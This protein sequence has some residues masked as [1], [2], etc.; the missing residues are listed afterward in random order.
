MSNTKFTEGPW[1]FD[2]R[3]EHLENPAGTDIV[4][5]HAGLMG[6]AKTEE[7]VANSNL[8]EASPLLYKALEDVRNLVSEASAT[9]FNPHDGDWAD[10]LFESQAQ[11][12][13]ALAS[14]RGE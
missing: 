9:G 8:I 3:G 1:A 11:T 10:R 13:K 7:S 12:S 6:G 5:Y 2:K 4:V 14:A